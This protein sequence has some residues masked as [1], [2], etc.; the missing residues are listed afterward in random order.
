MTVNVSTHFDGSSLYH[1]YI[2]KGVSEEY[3][4]ILTDK[5]IHLSDHN[6]VEVILESK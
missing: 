5:N 2:L 1:M 6:S 3:I 4:V